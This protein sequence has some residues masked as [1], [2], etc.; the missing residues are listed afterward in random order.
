MIDVRPEVLRMTKFSHDCFMLY[1]V[2]SV[3]FFKRSRICFYCSLKLL[4]KCI[5]LRKGITWLTI[6]VCLG[7]QFYCLMKLDTQRMP[8]TWH[9]SLLHVIEYTSTCSQIELT[10]SEMIGIC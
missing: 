4:Y 9:K 7:C 6:E 1:S 10:T 5:M 3:L 2:V 8:H